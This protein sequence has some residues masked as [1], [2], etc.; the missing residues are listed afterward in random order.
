MLAGG[1]RV[2]LGTGAPLTPVGLHLHLALRALHRYGFTPAEALTTATRTPARVF[3]VAG[4]LGT[5]EPC[6][7]ADLT[8]IDGDPFSDFDDLVRVRAAVTG[9]AVHERRALERTVAGA[10]RTAGAVRTAGPA[11]D[12]Q[13]VPR[14]MLSDGCCTPRSPGHRP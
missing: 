14:Q 10:A 7:L 13:P 11:P 12:W 2:A 9:G 3:G 5:V 1:G 6:K 8:V 4:R